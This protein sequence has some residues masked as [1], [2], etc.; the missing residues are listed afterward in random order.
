VSPVYLSWRARDVGSSLPI[1]DLARKNNDEAPDLI[2]GRVAVELARN[3]GIAVKGARVLILGIAYKKNVE[4]TR[5]SPALAILNRLEEMGAVCDYHDPY[6]PVM[7]VTR[8]HPR[9]AGRRSAELTADGLAAY[10]AVLLA[11]D[12]SGVDYVL[13]AQHARLILDTRNVFAAAGLSPAHGK[14]IKA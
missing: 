3:G 4:D 9:L 2:A 14:L 13:V 10:D 7:P 1:V 11:T 5:E 6:F 12:H 8:D